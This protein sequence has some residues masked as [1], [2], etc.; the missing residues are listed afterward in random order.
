MVHARLDVATQARVGPEQAARHLAEPRRTRRLHPVERE[1][2]AQPARALDLIEFTG[3]SL[4]VRRE[5]DAHPEQRQRERAHRRPAQRVRRL[6]GAIRAHAADRGL[7]QRQHGIEPGGGAD[8]KAGNQQRIV[9]IVALL[10]LA[11]LDE[12]RAGGQPDDQHRAAQAGL[13]PPAPRVVEQRPVRARGSIGFAFLVEALH[14]LGARA[15][16]AQPHPQRDAQRRQEGQEIVRRVV[17]E[18]DGEVATLQQGEEVGDEGLRAFAERHIADDLG[19]LGEVVGVD[20]LQVRIACRN[21]EVDVERA[22]DAQEAEPEQGRRMLQQALPA[23]LVAGRQRLRQREDEQREERAERVEARRRGGAEQQ[24]APEEA[25]RQG[26]PDAEHHPR[27]GK[28]DAGEVGGGLQHLASRQVQAEG[29]HAGP[30]AD[31]GAGDAPGGQASDERGGG[32]QQLADDE[33][34]AED[35]VEQRGNADVQRRVREEEVA[36]GQLALAPQARGVEV[37]AFVGGGEAQAVD[38]ED[39]PHGDE[40]G[41]GDGFG[42][43]LQRG[44]GVVAAHAQHEREAA[45]GERD[46]SG[47]LDCEAEASHAGVQGPGDAQGGERA[48]DAEQGRA[49]QA[50][51]QRETGEERGRQHGFDDD[52][53]AAWERDVRRWRRRIGDAGQSGEGGNH[54]CAQPTDRQEGVQPQAKAADAGQRPGRAGLGIERQRAQA[55]HRDRCRHRRR[56]AEQAIAQRLRPAG[57]QRRVRQLAQAQAEERGDGGSKQGHACDLAGRVGAPE[58]RRQRGTAKAQPSQ[59]QGRVR[60]HRKARR[61]TARHALGRRDQRQTGRDQRRGQPVRRLL[62]SSRWLRRG[63]GGRRRQRFCLEVRRIRSARRRSRGGLLLLARHR[64]VSRAATGRENRPAQPSSLV[65]PP[66]RD[67]NDAQPLR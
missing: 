18:R 26:G 12:Q 13:A 53:G 67:R 59:D 25:P 62:L 46:R 57:A 16:P 20:A 10:E 40:H 24:A 9:E 54:R 23:R 7:T 41:D 45:G 44:Q 50:A 61:R 32:G 58:P 5:V 29:E 66:R 38:L 30:D 21:R 15:Q 37:E 19:L 11:E 51:G 65:P 42:G 48:G 4:A 28:V 1:A 27:D 56:E 47:D 8:C 60:Q 52:E 17:V 35:G 34:V 22:P 2:F 3:I 39:D 14:L 31:V 63:L 55:S 33:V 64:L 6:P 43:H 49:R 36:V